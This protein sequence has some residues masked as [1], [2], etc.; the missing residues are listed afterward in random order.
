[1]FR[2]KL[3]E[4]RENKGVSQYKFADDLALSQSTIGN[5]EAGKREP[6]FDTLVKIAQYFNVSID[7]LLDVE[8]SVYTVEDY[9]NG[10]TDTKKVSI[11]ADDEDMLDKY[12]EVVG[13]LGEKG[14][15]LIIEFCDMLLDKFGR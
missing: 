6:N 8:N 12:H 14:K 9:A 13:L 2:L 15:N 4:L 10:V 7:Y 3:K 11:T 5:W 1:M